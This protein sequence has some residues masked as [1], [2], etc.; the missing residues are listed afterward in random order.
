MFIVCGLELENQTLFA[1]SVG[2]VHVA[3]FVD[4]FLAMAVGDKGQLRDQDH[5]LVHSRTAV[6]AL[7]RTVAQIGDQ[8]RPHLVGHID[9]G[10]P[11]VADLVARQAVVFMLQL[12]A[13]F[14]DDV[15]DARQRVGRARDGDHVLARQF[16]LV[17]RPSGQQR[18]G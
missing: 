10:E 7:R 18:A 1:G 8:G 17:A 16:D 4:F 6:E 13:T 5:R 12:S 9:A 11:Q 15:A 2:E 3:K 14:P